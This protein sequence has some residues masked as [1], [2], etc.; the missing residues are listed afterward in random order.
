M[1]DGLDDEDYL[2]EKITEKKRWLSSGQVKALEKIFE[3]DNKLEPDRKAK[4]AAELGLQPRQFTDKINGNN[5]F[6][7]WQRRIK[8]LLVQRGLHKALQ[9]KEKMPEQMSE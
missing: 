2:E 1:L 4:L 8:D 5:N 7:L 6:F 3:V 9:G